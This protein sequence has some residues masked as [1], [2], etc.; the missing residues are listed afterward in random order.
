MDYQSPRNYPPTASNPRP[1]YP[2]G[3]K[4]AGIYGAIPRGKSIEH[5]MREIL[6]C[7]EQSGQTP[8]AADLT[9]LWQAIQW[10]VT[11]GGGGG[12]P[13]SVDF[14]FTPMFPEVVTNAGVFLLTPTAGQIVVANGTTFVHRGGNKFLTADTL[15]ADRTFVT[16]ANKTYHLRWRYNG[17]APA[18]ALKDLADGAYNPGILA[19]DHA[20]FDATYDDMLIARVVTNGANALTVTSL[21]NRA[22]L[23]VDKVVEGIHDGDSAPLGTNGVA[24]LFADTLNWSRKPATK[25]MVAIVRASNESQDADF[26]ISTQPAESG[27]TPQIPVTRY[28]LSA[29]VMD[30]YVT[31]LSMH[32]SARA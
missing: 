25:T 4:P 15:I 1:A 27:S 12:T 6:Y 8:S 19:E 20:A 23:F 22:Q 26:V 5:P 21:V 29:A 14:S 17:G 24:F 18:Y 16:A 11:M 31:E 13:P 7:I 10:A 32:W 2:D 28:A 3:D 30:D 9:Q